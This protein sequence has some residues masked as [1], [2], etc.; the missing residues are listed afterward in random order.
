MIKKN[1]N[2]PQSL[3]AT[4][5]LYC[6]GYYFLDNLAFGYGLTFSNDFYEFKDWIKL[7]SEEKNKRINDVYDGVKIEAEKVREWLEN[8]KVI[9]TGE[10]DEMNYHKFVDNRTEIEKQPTSY[11]IFKNESF[12]NKS[13]LNSVKEYF[14]DLFG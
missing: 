3:I 2:F 11:Q 6:H 1:E 13:I 12:R 4:Y 14:K 7:S 10:R 5:D 8:R 9:L